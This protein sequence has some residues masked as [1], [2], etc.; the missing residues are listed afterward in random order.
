MSDLQCTLAPLTRDLHSRHIVKE[1][2]RPL[3]ETKRA[4]QTRQRLRRQLDLL[5]R[6]VG[7][8]EGLAGSRGGGRLGSIIKELRAQARR[9]ERQLSASRRAKVSP[10]ATKTPPNNK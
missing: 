3:V 8:L 1:E 5:R 2:W 10:E 6:V 4:R 9:L 7:R